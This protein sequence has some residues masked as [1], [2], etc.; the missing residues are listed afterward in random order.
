MNPLVV[1][2]LGP[3][4]CQTGFNS[5]NAQ[6]LFPDSE[7]PVQYRGRGSLPA[8]KNLPELYEQ[9]RRLYEALN[10]R[11]RSRLSA[12]DLIEFEPEPITNV[13]RV[14]LL[15]LSERL[16]GEINQWLNSP[17][18]RK[19][20][21]QLRVKLDPKENV[22][23]II[24]TDDPLLQKLPW[25]LWRFFKDY[26]KAEV[27]LSSPEYEVASQ[28]TTAI[29]RRMR[30][31]VVLGHSEGIDTQVDRLMLED[32]D[33][34]TIFLSNPNRAELDRQLW[35]DKGWDIFFFAGHSTSHAV[36]GKG[37]FKE[38]LFL[39]SD[40]KLSI[41]E[42]RNALSASI[43]RGLK[44]AIFNS[45]DGLG[46]ARAL[47]DLNIPQLIVMR[48]PVVDPVAHAFLEN[49]LQTFSHGE[50]F[51]TAARYA[52]EKLQGLEGKYP[53]ASWLPVI[54]QN[55]TEAPIVWTKG[56]EPPQSQSLLI[57]PREPQPQPVKSKTLSDINWRHLLVTSLAVTLPLVGVRA[58]GLLQPLEL[59]AYDHLIRSRP[60][61]WEQ[62]AVDQRLLVIEIDQDDT[63][64]YGYPIR[65]GVLAAALDQL[66]QRQPRAVGIDMHR[67]Q[68]NEPG[69]E[70]LLE[71]FEKS[72]DLITV[73]SFDQ[74]DREILGHPPEFSRYQAE[75]QVGF[76]D[77]EIDDDYQ[78]NRPVVRRHLLSYDPHLGPISSACSTPYSLSL[79][80]ALRFL[81]KEGVQPLN[82]NTQ[83]NW[84]LGPVVFNRLAVRTGGYQQL[85]GQSSQI[86][87]NY[88]FKPKP[89]HRISFTDLLEGRFND[90]L[91]RD[92]IVLM[93]VTDPIANDI[94]ETPFG[95]LPGVWVHAHGVSQ[96][97][98]AVLDERPLIWVLP[99]VGQWQWGDMLWI[100]GWAVVGGVLVWCIRRP[101]MVLLVVGGASVGLRQVC[102][103]LLVQG[104][105]VPLV[106]ALFALGGT[107][108][109]LLAYKHGYLRVI[110]GAVS[111]LT[112]RVGS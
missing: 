49:F 106:P 112:I 19:I 91:I 30:V 85:D 8:A 109:V 2:N 52:R 36:D 20:D 111:K 34:D 96:L 80:L 105:W 84:H 99:Q 100:W 63:D 78:R 11:F 43:S 39:N 1:L 46:L 77:L 7:L 88:R 50:A 47:A 27:A 58:L 42:L 103:L 10:N 82:A 5:V 70:E 29:S 101:V 15:E 45:C 98:A 31:L 66:R 44:L 72:P 56:A 51:Y 90:N 9:W 54:F 89:A 38:Q 18:F 86:L 14:D 73:C 55:P 22:R 12:K 64:K 71:Q 83:Q 69:R 74:S 62:P 35:D 67:Y 41:D 28:T 48:E 68:V 17:G 4:N 79:N 97:L 21:Q 53:G 107:A 13:S 65:D 37:K 87:L 75:H 110:T 95:T 92:R 61:S 33:A 25:H 102:L 3:G 93:G 60:V 57:E 40:E 81:R 16:E 23:V 108:G 104:G 6:L 94:R 26:T 24:E 59:S 76:S 32:V